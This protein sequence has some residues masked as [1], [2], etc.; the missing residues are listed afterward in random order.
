[1][2]GCKVQWAWGANEQAAFDTLKQALCTAP[3]LLMPDLRGDFFVD[4]DASQ[5]SIGGVILQ[6]AGK[7]VQP[8]GVLQQETDWC[9]CQLSHP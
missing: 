3:V 1:M 4:I 9:T 5:R 2:L 7:G 6:D 8:V